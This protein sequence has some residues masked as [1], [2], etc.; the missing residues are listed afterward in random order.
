VRDLAQLGALIAA[1]VVPLLAYGA[2]GLAVVRIL[3]LR[4]G[5]GET[6][7]LAFVFG[8]GA[9]SLAILG[10]RLADLPLPLWA[11]AGVALAGIPLARGLAP[12]PGTGTR[13]GGA[14]IRALE[15]T[16]AAL[17]ALTFAGWTSCTCPRSPRANPMQRP[18]YR[19]ASP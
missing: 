14:W 19:R 13:A 17:A 2:L 12:R 11:L 9:S 16:G 15:W 1:G 5:T 3:R 18:A 7:A 8:T 6:L 10:L 4:A